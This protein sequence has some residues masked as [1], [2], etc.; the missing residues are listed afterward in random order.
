MKARLAELRSRA[1]RDSIDLQLRW[2]WNTPFFISAHN[3]SVFYAG[4]NRVMKSVKRG[5]EMFAIS[6]DLSTNDTMKIRV[7]TRTTGGIT[8]DAT[9]AET[10]SNIVSLN[11][12][13]MRPGF[14]YA[15]TDD[16][17]VW[18]SRNDGGAWEN[19]TGRFPGVPKNTYVS[20][21]EP[22]STDSATFYVTFD[23]HRS[24]DFTPYVYATNDYGKTFRS[25]VNNLPSGGL[26]FV[27]V[28]REDPGNPDLLFLGSETGLFFSSD[29]GA[30]WRKLMSGFPTV[31]VHDLKIHPRDRDLIAATHGRSIWVVNVAPLEQLS[32]AA[33]SAKAHL[34]Q[35]VTAW[36]YSSSPDDA[37]IGGG[38]G[39]G[40]MRF[41]S[42]SA[43]YGAEIVYRVAPGAGSGQARISIVDAGGDTL[44]TLT[45]SSGAGLQRVYWAFNGKNPAR[46]PLSPA[47]KRDSAALIAR[48]DKAVDSM[49]AAGGSKPALDSAKTQL[50]TLAGGGGGFGGGGFGGGGGAPGLPSFIPRPGEGP[51]QGAGGG[52]GGG[53]WRTRRQPA[54]SGAGRF[55]GNPGA[56]WRRR[57]RRIRR[58]WCPDRR[59]RRLPRRGRGRRAEAHPEAAG[60]EVGGD[61]VTAG[62]GEQGVGNGGCRG[63]HDA[64]FLS[65]PFTTDYSLLPPP[66]AYRPG[67]IVSPIPTDKRRS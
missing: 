55:P 41:Q 37:M 60:R 64:P 40:Q 20:R 63:N 13:P 47:Q 33:L 66:C 1:T 46:P 44:R 27:H 35:P 36:Q 26:D 15:G 50:L 22:S 58:W 34:F 52:G 59:A 18:I 39:G 56:D 49:V 25:I 57:W 29:R 10:Y 67:W 12:S 19:L 45:G 3:P 53:R 5:D 2:N 9:G 42:N 8:T 24:G 38:G 4:A 32:D 21:I 43:P 62:S 51:V 7:S 17:N 14:L 16:G 11:E 23:G 28:I 6:P 61:L 54:G 30:S 48:I 65:L 31:P